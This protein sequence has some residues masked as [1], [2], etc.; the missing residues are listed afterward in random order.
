M[1]TWEHYN[2]ENEAPVI[3]GHTNEMPQPS[4]D[5]LP[6]PNIN[7]AQI[8]STEQ[9]RQPPRKHKRNFY[10]KN[11]K[12]TQILS[13]LAGLVSFA[14]FII[15]F[16]TNATF[17]TCSTNPLFSRITLSLIFSFVIGLTSNF[18]LVQYFRKKLT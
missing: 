12:K 6:L 14:L 10:L 13:W 18:F 5:E 7:L 9:S 2:P 16:Q 8:Y 3:S 11:R 1:S 15:L 17:T 4:P